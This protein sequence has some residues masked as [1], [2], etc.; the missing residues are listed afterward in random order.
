MN[1]K[2]PVLF[3]ISLSRLFKFKYASFWVRNSVRSS[4]IL[5][6]L[7]IESNGKTITWKIPL[8]SIILNKYIYIY[9]KDP[10][11]A[12]ILLLFHTTN[13]RGNN[14][15]RNKSSIKT[16]I[17]LDIYGWWVGFSFGD[18]IIMR[19]RKC[20]VDIITMEAISFR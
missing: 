12:I 7:A 13:H 15:M 14:K 1:K 6:S 9:I 5:S 20:D 3:F 18:N 8:W 11:V 10:S 16:K 17:M 4:V 2:W 19:F